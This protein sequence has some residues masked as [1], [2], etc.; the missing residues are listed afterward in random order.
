MLYTFFLGGGAGFL[1]SLC[2]PGCPG[3]HSVDQVGLELRNPPA[4]ASQVLGLKVCATT[5]RPCLY[6]LNTI[7]NEKVCHIR[8]G[9]IIFLLPFQIITV[10]PRAGQINC[11]TTS[12]SIHNKKSTLQ[13]GLE[14]RF[15][16]YQKPKQECGK[17]QET[18]G[19]REQG[20]K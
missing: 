15:E 3:I 8:G 18:K 10:V 13:S 14:L 20:S 17:R 7:L 5:A 6:H 4:S 2:S 9:K 16:C 11:R 12:F 19:S 1:F